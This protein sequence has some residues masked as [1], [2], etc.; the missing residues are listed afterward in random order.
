MASKPTVT[1]T[2]AGD[3]GKLTDAFDKVGDASKSMADKVDSASSE[4][5]GAGDRFDSLAESTDTAE[6]RFTGF[7]D[8]IGGVTEG[9]MAW[10]DES[11]ST[12]ER[13][14]ALGMA[15]ADLAGGLTGFLVP[16]LKTMWTT[17]TT[18]VIPAIWSFTSALLANPITWV[19]VGIAA[20]IAIIILLVKNWDKVKE[21]VGTVVGW[22]RD[23]WNG[24]MSWFSG[25]P[26]WFGRIFSGIGNAISGAF[27]SA[28]NWVIDKVNWL[29]DRVNWLLDQI[30]GVSSI[31]GIPAIPHIPHIPR[32]HTGGTVPGPPG[33]EQM[34]ILQ[35]GETVTSAAS[36]GATAITINSGGSALD[37]ALV[38]VLR[39]AIQRQG[40]NVQVVL[41]T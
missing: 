29:L 7:S 26:D 12:T 5:R 22:I 37:D 8:T 19:V 14:Q 31:V 34:A 18:T 17:L 28:I 38:E 25:I 30:N 36:S 11:L 40:G 13:L 24:L 16:A 21:V 23:R 10:N 39:A 15:G 4:M 2:L 6:T 35:A 3:E 1:M 27:K 41:G 20:L 32:M 33:S 9:L